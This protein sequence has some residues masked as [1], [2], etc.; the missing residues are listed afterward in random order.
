MISMIEEVLKVEE[1]FKNGDT[2]SKFTTSSIK[3]SKIHAYVKDNLKEICYDKFG[4]CFMQK[5]ISILRPKHQNEIIKLV[6]SLTKEFIDHVYAN[7]VI[8]Y[9]ISLN[10][11]KYNQ[12][13][14]K[15]I[16]EKLVYYSKNKS[17]SNVIEKLLELHDNCNELVEKLLE[18]PNG[19][20]DLVL[21]CYGN[22]GKISIILIQSSV[23]VYD[24][25]QQ[26]QICWGPI[27]WSN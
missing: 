19:V 3:F 10:V 18:T 6:I 9:L 17:T 4:C 11:P 23:F 20:K 14:M 21:D 8:Q 24:R 15:V 13:F 5:Y 25:A 2:A 22:Y 1:E 26:M 16:G 7:Y 12:F 27:G